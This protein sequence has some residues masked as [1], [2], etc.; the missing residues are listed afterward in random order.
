MSVSRLAWPGVALSLT[1]VDDMLAGPLLAAVGAWIAGPTGIA[2]GVGLFT[3][4]VGALVASV[5]L[6]GPAL[7]DRTQQRIDAAVQRA[8]R[9]RVTGGAVRRVGDSHPWST[10]LIAALVSPVLAVLLAQAV[11]PGQPLRR[12]ALVATLAYGLAFALFYSGL[13][14]GAAALV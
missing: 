13:G 11:H 2:L 9:R 1:F 7:D 4:V 3:A 12:T 14:S 8:Q 10:A 6:T 5:L